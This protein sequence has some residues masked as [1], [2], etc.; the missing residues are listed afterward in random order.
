MRMIW[1]ATLMFFLIVQPAL[2]HDPRGGSIPKAY[3]DFQMKREALN[4][5]M[6][7]AGAYRGVFGLSTLWS[8]RFTKLRVCFL[9][10]DVKIRQYVAEIGNLWNLANSSMK[11]DFG[12]MSSPR[13][14]NPQKE[15]QIRISFVGDGY[16]SL[17]GIDSIKFDPTEASLVLSEFDKM[18]DEQLANPI[19]KGIVL[20][21]LGHALGLLHEHQS[22]AI[23]CD[24][25]YNWDYIYSK[26]ADAPNNWSKDMVDH[27]MRTL[28]GPDYV[29][30]G[31]DRT[32]IMIY[33]F[34]EA[35]YKV[36]T[37]SPCY[38]EPRTAISAQD[39]QTLSEMYPADKD[40]RSQN[41]ME[42]RFGFGQ[43]WKKINTSTDRSTR[44]KLDLMQLYYGD[45]K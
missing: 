42:R 19:V 38:A 34:P 16:Y 40:V 1:S 6:K 44:P 21:E 15:N 30:P 26:M 5:K 18:P 25:E 32:S 43:A 39:Y 28:W 20:H 35:Y 23:D 3:L 7:S 45:V 27:N 14:C 33:D 2:A 9:D 36:G 22:P 29:A 31:Y 24:A 41:Y 37:I 4:Q 13:S 8:P 11:L 17:E 10:G 12:K